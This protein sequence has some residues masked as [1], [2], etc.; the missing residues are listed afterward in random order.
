MSLDPAFVPILPRTA[1]ATAEGH[2]TVG[3]RDMVEL[4]REFGTPLYV[5]DEVELREGCR[6]WLGEFRSR[7][8]GTTGI[9]AAKAHLGRALRPPPA[10]HHR[11]PLGQRGV[12]GDAVGTGLQPP[13]RPRRWGA[14]PPSWWGLS[15]LSGCLPSAAPP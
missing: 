6:E 12:G 11:A 5:F 10:P 3:G 1:G 7:Y 15:L 8:E 9:Y 13:R 14:P 2:L 4:A